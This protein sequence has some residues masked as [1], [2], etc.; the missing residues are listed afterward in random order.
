MEA[1]RPKAAAG[2][3]DDL[4]GEL[5][6]DMNAELGRLVSDFFNVALPSDAN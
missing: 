2:F 6:A 4:V 5:I 1:K 3:G